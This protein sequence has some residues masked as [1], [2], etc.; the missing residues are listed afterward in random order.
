MNAVGDYLP[1]NVKCAIAEGGYKE[2]KDIIQ[3]KS[4]RY[5]EIQW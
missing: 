1:R 3:T 5:H 4:S 2:I